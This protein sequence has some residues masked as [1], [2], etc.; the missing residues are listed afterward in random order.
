[1]EDL[2]IIFAQNLIALRKQMKLTQIELAEK[3]NYSDKAVSKWE[4]G[5]SIPDVSVLMVIA[6]LFGVSIDFLVTKH[7]NDEIAKEQT[8]YAAGIKKKNRSLITAITFFAMLI[9]ETV[10]FIALQGAKPDNLGWNIVYC[11][12][13]PLPI[14][15]I[16]AV[17]FSSLWWSK[18]INFAAVSFLI[19][20]VVTDAFLIVLLAWK[21]FPLI[22]LVVIPA[23]IVAMMSFKIKVLSKVLNTE[24][25]KTE[26]KE[27]AQ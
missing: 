9:L 2:K 5:E 18:Y 27:K 8:S 21:P 10:V 23:E 13:F 22:Y 25:K 17:V 11:Y 19:C 26:D 6:N 24:K 16:V 15:A 7:E 14:F 1:M 12:V 20:S 4:R 3:I